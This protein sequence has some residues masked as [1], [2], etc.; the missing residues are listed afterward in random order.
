LVHWLKQFLGYYPADYL[1][2]Y[3]V[4]INPYSQDDLNFDWD[5]F[6]TRII[7]N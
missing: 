4:S 3:L 2:F 1:R 7:L 6:T 5:D